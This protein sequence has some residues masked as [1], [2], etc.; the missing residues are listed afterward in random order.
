MGPKFKGKCASKRQRQKYRRKGH[1]KEE[2]EAGVTE[3]QANDTAEPPEAGRS[4]R[5]PPLRA[6]F[7]GETAVALLTL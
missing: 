7:K 6:R 4:K 3:S 5:G 2:A 1:V